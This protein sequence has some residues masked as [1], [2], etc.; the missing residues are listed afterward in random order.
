MW[1]RYA[2]PTRARS[3]GRPLVETLRSLSTTLGQ[4][5]VLII[6]DERAVLTISEFRDE[7]AGL[8]R[9]RLPKHEIVM[10]LSNKG[11][12]HQFATANGLPVPQAEVVR[13]PQDI[14]LVKQLRCPVIMKPADKRNVH[15]GRAPRVVVA[16]DWESAERSCQELHKVA[17]DVIV[18][19][20]VEG[21]DSAIY[22]CLFYCKSG[23]E[24]VMFTGR[25]LT[26]TPQGVGSTAYCTAAKDVCGLEELTRSILERVDFVGFGSIEY[27]W[28]PASERFVIIEPTVGRTNWQE[29]IATLSGVNLPLAGYCYEC[30]LPPPIQTPPERPVVWRA[31]YLEQM[32]VGSPVIPPDSVIVDGYWRRDDPMPAFVQYPRELAE[33]FRQW[34][35]P[36]TERLRRTYRN[37]LARLGDNV[38]K[39]TGRGHP[40][41]GHTGAHDDRAADDPVGPTRV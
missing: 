20:F 4:A 36:E 13:R 32:K 9:I 3:P 29:E 11:H 10:M 33:L 38:R 23:A 28:D 41:L 39:T 26:S 16:N 15:V 7:L 40:R 25:K 24:T 17:G 30:G 12:F 1:S 22:F 5:P 21:P 34:A 8:F 35:H 37:W 2:R 19:E 6:T 18:Q 14:L 31:S 27:K